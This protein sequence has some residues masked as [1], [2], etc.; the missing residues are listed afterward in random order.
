MA[1][2]PP[3]TDEHEELRESLRRF[4]D[5]ELRPHAEE[6]ED[7]R[8]FPN[9]V[10]TQLA[11]HGFLGL[12]YPESYGGQGG[13]YLHE[14][15]MCEEMARIGSGGTAAGIGAHINIAT[16][17]I[18]EFG[19]DDQKDRYLKPAI[20]GRGIGALGLTQPA[21]GSGG[22]RHRTRAEKG[23]GGWGGQR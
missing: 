22:A 12:K 15:V 3:F 13:D 7:A 8:W 11:E 17:P 23:G 6:W 19:T 1:P 14:A 20:A 18:W 10:F 5:A 16:P 2:E 9:E 4:I 21:A